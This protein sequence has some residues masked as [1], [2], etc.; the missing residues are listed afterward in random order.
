M[1]VI[2]YRK[3]AKAKKVYYFMGTQQDCY[4][5]LNTNGHAMQHIDWI[6]SDKNHWVC[7]EYYRN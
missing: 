3:E 1:I 6:E 7:A 5:I 2:K 4:D